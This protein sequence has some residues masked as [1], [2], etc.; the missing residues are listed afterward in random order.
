MEVGAEARP[1]ARVRFSQLWR[2]RSDFLVPAAMVLVYVLGVLPSLGQTLL[3]SHAQ[4]QTQTALTALLYAQHG[5]DLLRPPLPVLGPP[6][7]IPQELPLFQA[8]GALLIRAG[9]GPDLAM[10]L[11][12]LATFIGSAFILFLLARRLLPAFASYIVLAAY[13]FNA[14]AWVYGR[15]A[16]IEYLA[17]GGSVA[18]LY[19]GIRW[20]EGAR[21]ADWLLALLSGFVAILVKIT[22]GG[23]YLLPLLLWRDREGR[24]GF[25]RRSVWALVAMTV[26][27][28]LA[29]SA[30]A[31]HVR[32]ETPASVFLSL[33]NQYG[34]FFGTLTER[35]TLSEWRRPLVAFL[36][37]TGSGVLVWAILAVKRA[38]THRQPA[39]MLCLLVLTVAIPLLLF[40][41][42]AVH[43]YY[44]VALAPLV[45]IAIGLGADWLAAHRRGRW[46]RRAIVGLAGAWVFTI[47]GLI[48]SWSIIYGTPREQARALQIAEFIA[49]HSA[50]DD[51][52]VLRGWGWNPAFFYYAHR[53][54]LAV[55]DESTLQDTTE[56]DIDQILANP[57]FGP[58]ITCDRVPRCVVEQP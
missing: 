50:P 30:Y 1:I 31:Q 33:E 58:F 8:V 49:D 17:V 36:M 42:Y 47:I 38:H 21:R 51:W 57:V 2:A 54:G 11:V 29:W 35:L 20:L 15:T 19:F 16:L 12:G 55:P 34:W 39:F 28:G 32:E 7:I 37:L 6:G 44:Y 26:A 43:D 48:P 53:Q 18:F 9:I 13:L 46:A 5:I 40:N 56:I 14:H 22:T 23:F 41:L 24:W 4:R 3:E 27:V 45:A 25:Q 52:V 10:R